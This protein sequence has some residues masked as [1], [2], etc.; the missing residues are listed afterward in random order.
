MRRILLALVLLTLAAPAA[1]QVQ[2][3]RTDP[4][5]STTRSINGTCKGLTV[6]TASNPATGFV[7]KA[8]VEDASTGDN[9][10]AAL[11]DATDNNTVLAQSAIVTTVGAVGEYT[12]SGGDF[13]TYD[14]GNGDT[15]HIVV[16][17]DSAAGA[18]AYQS[19]GGTAFNGVASSNTVTVSPNLVI[20]PATMALDTAGVGDRRYVIY[21]EY[22]EEG[23]GGGVTTTIGNLTTTGVGR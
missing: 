11:V 9:F 18:N 23:G 5:G 3:G 13:A 10:R 8:R 7:I 1:A 21:M 17:S 6:T 4:T 16:C 2:L 15:F 12:F 20:A 14:P 22:T 19:N